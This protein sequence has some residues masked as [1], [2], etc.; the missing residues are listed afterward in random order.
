VANLEPT[1]EILSRTSPNLLDLLVALLS[2]AA[3]AYALSRSQLAGALP[4]VAIAAAL[5]PP[6]CVVGYGIGTGQFD[7]AAG[8]GLLFVAN[9][10]AITVSA[11]AVF[12]LLGFRPSVR[13]ERGEQARHGLTISLVVLGIVA[14]VLV[15]FTY[16]SSQQGND[17]NTIESI[18]NAALNPN[19][20]SIENIQ[21]S[22]DRRGY[23]VDFIVLDYSGNFHDQDVYALSVQT[24]NAV[25][26][27]VTMRASIVD[28][29]LSISN[30][31][32]L[33]QPTSRP[34]P[35]A[36]MQPELTRA[37]L[38]TRTVKPSVTAT[39][40]PTIIRTLVPSPT[41]TF[42]P[43]ATTEP[44][45]ESTKPPNPEP[46]VP[47]SPTLEVT[48]TPE[49]TETPM[50]TKPPLETETPFPTVTPGTP[51]PSTFSSFPR[52]PALFL[53]HD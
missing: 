19:Q 53:K 12:L 17:R 45:A 1:N 44:T 28:S 33:P 36:T 46:T 52:S 35:T 43:T 7:I 10:A 24:G 50:P 27:Q 15:T 11:A 38:I 3:A 26:K 29:R 21:F 25:H 9:L 31:D 47:I 2:G 13:I 32:V 5:V 8:A 14:L 51:E 4:G 23:V 37:P 18:L 30:G 42:A 40:M 16:F 48:P 20:G 41:V 6:L 34:S 22:R 39:M 49:L